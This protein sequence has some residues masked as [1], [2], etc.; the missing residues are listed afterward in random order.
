[1]TTLTSAPRTHTAIF[2]HLARITGYNYGMYA[3]TGGQ[4]ES[5]SNRGRRHAVGATGGASGPL[6]PRRPCR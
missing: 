6:D 3:D 4:D 5:V 1:M 2:A